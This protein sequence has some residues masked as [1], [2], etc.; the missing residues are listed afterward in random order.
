MLKKESIG[1]GVKKIFPYFYMFLVFIISL[2]LFIFLDVSHL[3]EGHAS[4][5]SYMF[6]D[7]TR[8]AEMQLEGKTFEK[9]YND[10]EFKNDFKFEFAHRIF[11]DYDE[12]KENFLKNVEE[13]KE[14][15]ELYDKYGENFIKMLYS[16]SNYN[17]KLDLLFLFKLVLFFVLFIIIGMVLY[18]YLSILGS[19]IGLIISFIIYYWFIDRP[20]IYFLPICGIVFVFIYNLINYFMVIKKKKN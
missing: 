11:I 18:K 10:M 9:L 14:R 16:N 12:Y 5:T 2:F 3:M 17:L 19:I 13:S 15:K 20:V 8:F 6:Y 7:E 4:V 1:I